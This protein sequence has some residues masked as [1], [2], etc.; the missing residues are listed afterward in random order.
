MCLTEIDGKSKKVHQLLKLSPIIFQSC[1]DR[2][3][4]RVDE[5]MILKINIIKNRKIYC[6]S[7]F[8]SLT[9]DGSPFLTHQGI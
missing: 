4:K 7:S 6:H 3:W 8:H 9:V 5:S 1:K 2:E